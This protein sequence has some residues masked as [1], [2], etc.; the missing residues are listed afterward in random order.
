MNQVVAEWVMKAE[1]DHASA[2]RELR[3]QKPQLRF[4]LFSRATMR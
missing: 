1:G 3:A 4:C 2:L